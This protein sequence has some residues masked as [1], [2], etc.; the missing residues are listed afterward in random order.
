[1]SQNGKT[2]F[3]NLTAD[4]L[5]TSCM[6]RL[7]RLVLSCITITEAATK[8]HLKLAITVLPKESLLPNIKKYIFCNYVFLKN[9]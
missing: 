4:P 5:R 6:K 3:Q 2:H 1:M 8:E 7:R 9:K